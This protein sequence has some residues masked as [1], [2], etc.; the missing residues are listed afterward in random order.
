M[1]IGS[2]GEYLKAK[3]A[4]KGETIEFKD[5]GKIVESDRYTYED[6]SPK[7][8][9]VFEVYYKK[10]IKLLRVNKASRTAMIEAFGDETN[11]WIGKK[12]KIMI[13]PTPN[14]DNKMI[15]LDPMTEP[16]A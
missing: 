16:Q 15:V 8:D 14:G 4:D 6:G 7:K 11:D 10:E 13:M 12:A 1:K 3:T 9:Y 2:G 5:A